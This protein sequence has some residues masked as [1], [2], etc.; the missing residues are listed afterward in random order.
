MESPRN[1]SGRALSSLGGVCDIVTITDSAKQAGLSLDGEVDIDTEDLKSKYKRARARTEKQIGGEELESLIA[2]ALAGARDEVNRST[3]ELKQEARDRLKEATGT[4][5]PEFLRWA[6]QYAVDQGIAYVER[7]IIETFEAETDKLV[8]Y[9][10]AQLEQQIASLGGLSSPELAMAAFMPL[11]DLGVNN[12]QL[13]SIPSHPFTDELKR[14]GVSAEELVRISA[15]AFQ[16][17]KD[18]TREGKSLEDLVRERAR[19]AVASPEAIKESVEKAQ[20]AFEQL[21][22]VAESKEKL[23]NELE[24][25]GKNI[26]SSLSTIERVLNENINSNSFS[27]I[28][29]ALGDLEK[30]P[31]VDAVIGVNDR[32]NLKKFENLLDLADLSYGIIEGEVSLDAESKERIIALA[33]QVLPDAVNREEFKKAINVAQESLDALQAFNEG[34]WGDLSS[35][36][37]SIGKQTGIFGSGPQADK[38]AGVLQVAAQAAISYF[39]GDVSGMVSSA[40]SLFGGKKTSGDAAGAKRHQEVMEALKVVNS[41]IQELKQGQEKIY[42][43][44][45]EIRKT[46]VAIRRDIRDSTEKIIEVTRAGFIELFKGQEA[47]IDGIN[48]LAQGQE[49]IKQLVSEQIHDIRTQAAR[50]HTETM[51]LLTSIQGNINRLAGGIGA[52]L[53]SDLANC[54]VLQQERDKRDPLFFDS[55]GEFHSYAAFDAFFAKNGNLMANCL[56]AIQG[57]IVFVDPIAPADSGVFFPP[58]AKSIFTAPFEYN[59]SYRLTW[60]FLRDKRA[61]IHHFY[62]LTHPVRSRRE[63]DAKFKVKGTVPQDAAMHNQIIA[64][65]DPKAD[66]NIANP[67]AVAYIVEQLL[68]SYAYFELMT[69]DFKPL[70]FADLVTKDPEPFHRIGYEKIAR[71]ALPMLKSAIAQRQLLRGDLSLPL[72]AQGEC[73]ATPGEFFQLIHSNRM[74]ASN[75]PSYLLEADA[76]F[77]ACGVTYQWDPA[78]N[79]YRVLNPQAGATPASFIVQRP[80]VYGV[81]FA[82]HLTERLVRL[83]DEVEEALVGHELARELDRKSL[84]VYRAIVFHSLSLSRG[85]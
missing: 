42:E 69:S 24:T 78:T 67:E 11:A 76:G 12:W 20:A 55:N 52:L 8:D 84:R 26:Q 79:F 85:R 56:K 40:V 54:A 63:M 61:L 25:H 64:S 1:L 65:L 21:R 70:G 36:I 33:D 60:Q 75:L 31:F 82:D 66:Q 59:E 62:S 5:R 3:S 16:A 45:I 53:K 6:D 50:N 28:R 38:V 71:E 34:E 41:G 58:A 18:A 68:S 9:G 27:T 2:S 46:Q 7:K 51:R 74:L 83:Q 29:D 22:S 35:G 43:Q 48:R 10:F 13:A 77:T 17:L 81:L 72:I 44:T 23:I 57:Q 32:A 39:T 4:L 19:R 15:R 80:Q 49:E 37:I 30:E 73:P 47:T 14:Q